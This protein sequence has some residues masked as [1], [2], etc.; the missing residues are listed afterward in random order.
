MKKIFVIFVL[1]ILVFGC[2]EQLT[3]LKIWTL[4]QMI[5][6]ASYNDNSLALLLE[7]SVKILSLS[8]KNDADKD[9]NVG[10]NIEHGEILFNKD[11]LWIGDGSLANG[12]L[13][14]LNMPD[15]SLYQFNK[16]KYAEVY[17]ISLLENKNLLATGH[18]NGE[19][20]LWD[21]ITNKKKRCFG[22]YDIEVFAVEISPDG[23]ELYSGN[24]LGSVSLW[25]ISIGEK[26]KYNKVLN[27]IFTLD[28]DIKS[29]TV[30]CGGGD[31]ILCILDHK[32]LSV[33]K[34]MDFNRGAILSCDCRS[35]DSKI[36]CGL[37][38]GYIA[39]VNHDGTNQ[40]V[41][42]LHK[43][44]ILYV[45]FVDR[46]RKVVTVSKDGVIKLWDAGLM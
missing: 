11:N 26:V 13:F 30:A 12:I 17:A 27:S 1:L 34:R 41:L 38:G 33:I 28:Y 8:E 7:N 19:I 44:D 42:K 9:F 18:G 15:G 20:I 2:K 32:T 40:K 25:K 22:D 36:I 31:G 14:S 39:I 6:S 3:P 4:D 23:S 10:K 45:K 46:G 29:N 16:E 21:L 43:D 24:G 35:N 37:T 5:F